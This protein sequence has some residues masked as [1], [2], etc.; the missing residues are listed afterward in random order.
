MLVGEGERM[1]KSL[2]DSK[3]FKKGKALLKKK[4]FLICL[5]RHYFNCLIF[6][7][8]K[9]VSTFILKKKVN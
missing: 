4:F 2:Y 9:T 8:N 5:L 7:E 3:P 1:R 6:S